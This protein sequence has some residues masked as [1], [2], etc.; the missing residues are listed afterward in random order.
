MPLS[1]WI[2]A[3][4]QYGA[5]D[6][7]D[8]RPGA[9]RRALAVGIRRH[10]FS[11]LDGQSGFDSVVLAFDQ[12]ISQLQFAKAVEE[13]WQTL[14]VAVRA[15]EDAGGE[16]APESAPFFCLTLHGLSEAIALHTF[17]L[18]AADFT[19]NDESEEDEEENDSASPAFGDR[20]AALWTKQS[21][22]VGIIARLLLQSLPRSRDDVEAGTD[23]GCRLIAAALLGCL[24]AAMDQWFELRQDAPRKPRLI[25]VREP[26]LAK[27]LEALVAELPFHFTPQPL[28]EPVQYR[29]DDF[30]P[31]DAGERNYFRV[32]LIGYRRTNTFLRRLHA[33]AF[34]RDWMAPEFKRYV[35][36]V[37]IQQAVG[38]RI[39]LSLLGWAR[40]LADIGSDDTAS[41]STDTRQGIEDPGLDEAAIQTLREWVK[42]NFY[43]PASRHERKKYVRAGEFLDHPLMR[44][45]LAELCAIGAN[46]ERARFFLPWKADYRGRIYAATPW[47]TPQGGD[48]QRA[49]MEFA[50]GRPLDVAGIKALRRH[51]SNL[52]KR[53]RI[54][55]DL[56]VEG[57]EVVTLEERERWVLEHEAEILAS[58]VSPVRAA[59]WHEVSNK[60]MQFLAFCLAYRQWKL[61]PASP[62]HLPVQ[63]DGTCNGLQHIATLT[64]DAGLARAVNVLPRTDGLPGDVYSAIAARARETLGKITALLDR[65][66]PDLQGLVM[67]DTWLAAEPETWL[68]RTTAKQVIMTIPYGARPNR[69]AESVADAIAED[70][71]V[72]GRNFDTPDIDALCAWVAEDERRE[73]SVYRFTWGLFEE[74]RKD[75]FAGDAAAQLKLKRLQVVTAYAARVI[76]KHLRHAL[77]STF[78]VVDMFSGWL[79]E[80]ASVCDGLPLLWPTPLGFPVCQDKFT[81]EGSSASARLG[82][83][84]I[85][86]DLQHLGNVV[87]AKKQKDALLP[88]LIHSL[89]A[90]HLAMTLWEVHNCGI[91]GIGSIHDCLLC[92]PNDE[93]K[94]S[95]AVRKTFV[96]LYESGAG[97]LAKVLADW[98]EWME[99]IARLKTLRSATTVLGALDCP[100]GIGERTLAAYARW[101]DGDRDAARDALDVIGGLRSLPSSQRFLM[102]SLLEFM[103]D[104]AQAVDME[105]Q[106]QRKRNLVVP[107][108]FELKNETDISEYFFS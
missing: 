5:L 42:K 108:E 77:S 73:K 93:P 41:W 55:K 107:R 82:A 67:T 31:P 74:L 99:R 59:F 72:L 19:D 40:R 36:A 14:T 91:R 54:L 63:I 6:L 37:N 27:R 68:N 3:E 11:G 56:R 30:E 64:G 95:L 81:L 65:D 88:N 94:L 17:E 12:F 66:I 71:K 43:Y 61:E 89:D 46:G 86:I 78:P 32:D 44:S 97:S 2:P 83:K 13:L 9:M 25:A 85:R 69:Q 84:T 53:T 21:Q 96:Q 58:A 35:E 103:R 26:A 4:L 102:R 39:N 15:G 18:E 62:V 79:R 76:V 87:D 106:I 7:R 70:E 47:L 34:R 29:L 45:A 100:D 51:G 104:D 16:L 105:T 101:E 22:A 28:K 92:H 60:P 50:D 49:V 33:Q 1:L 48:L 10:L 38:W 57:R 90:T 80:T 8:A 98:S 24:L 20:G 52:A 23:K 75:A